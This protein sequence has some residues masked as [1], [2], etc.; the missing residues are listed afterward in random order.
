MV[1]L[2]PGLSGRR[3]SGVAIPR[4][5]MENNLRKHLKKFERDPTIKSKVMDLLSWYSGHVGG[6]TSPDVVME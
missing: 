6:I 3:R 1:V 4:N 5:S 2:A